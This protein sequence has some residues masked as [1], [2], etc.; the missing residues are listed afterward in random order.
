MRI[1]VSLVE[2]HYN[3][4]YFLFYAYFTYVQVVVPRVRLL[5]PL[6]Y[7][8]SV[9]EASVGIIYLLVEEVD[10]KATTFGNYEV[11]NSKIIMNLKTSSI[12]KRW[13][14]NCKETQ[15][16]IGEETKEG[17]GGDDNED[18]ND[19]RP[20]QVPLAITQGQVQ[21]QVKRK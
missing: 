16:K 4:V 17:K 18:I 9:D 11:E 7:K 12:I 2:K 15:R 21:D 5:R 19:D 14:E 3:N 8:I 20:T 1:L 13:E 6:P 10:K